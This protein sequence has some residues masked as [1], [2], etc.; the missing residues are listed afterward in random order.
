MSLANI[1]K[2]LRSYADPVRAKNALWFFKTKKGQYG[3]GDIFIGVT[4]PTMRII[5][6]KYKDIELSTVQQLLQSPIHEYRQ[7]ALLILVYKYPKADDV[8]R[9]RTCTL[10]LKSTKYINNW[11]L[12]DISAP[13]VVG[14]YLLD[15]P[16][17]RKILYTFARSKN[18]WKKRIAIISTFTFIRN[19]DFKDTLNISA[20]L[21]HDTHDLI[22]KAVGWM[23]REIGNRDIQTEEKFLKLHATHMPR[24]MLR[25]A[26]EKF[27]EK[28]RTSYLS[29]KY[30]R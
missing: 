15:K 6:K 26:I 3:E 10:Y 16:K 25:Y 19:N 13:H 9:K 5:A 24:T 12:V 1:Q 27:D 7:L 8:T 21:L 22:H 20:I 23:L 2:E 4:G 28:K 18:L 11:D 17:Q 14:R 29:M 30:A